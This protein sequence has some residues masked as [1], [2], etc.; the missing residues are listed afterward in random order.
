MTLWNDLPPLAEAARRPLPETDPVLDALDPDSRAGVAAVWAERAES[1]LGAGAVFAAVASGL[2]TASMPVEIVWLASRAVCDEL[3]HAE[4][5]R[6]V[7]A[8][9][10]G[11]VPARRPAIAPARPAPRPSGAPALDAGAH[12]ILNGAINETIGSA[13]LSACLEEATAPLARA[14][15]RELLTDETDHARLGWAVLAAS[16]E[17]GE[18][19]RVVTR[20]LPEMVTLARSVWRARAAELPAELPRG[21]G[22]L[23]GPAVAEL[24]DEALRALV[25]PGFAH[26]GIDPTAAAAAL[27]SDGSRYPVSLRLPHGRAPV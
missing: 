2:F 13:F 16:P 3:R 7:A 23:P 20:R 27:A 12:A 5:C 26:V 1:E 22:C 9:Y 21:H 10:S 24:V 15:L 14:A 19:R 11:V 25:L 6:H 8:R 4:I 18:T 17:G